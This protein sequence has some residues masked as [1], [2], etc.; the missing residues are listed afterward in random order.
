[1]AKLPTKTKLTAKQK[2]FC[3]EYLIDLNATAAAKRAGY[4]EKTAN[5][6][7]AQLMAMPHI[8]AIIDYELEARAKRTEITADRVLQELA[9]L[10]FVDPRNLFELDKRGNVK[11]KPSSELSDAD[12]ACI[13]GVTQNLTGTNIKLHD[14]IAALEKLGKHLKLFT[15]V[16]EQKHSFTQMGRVI[17]GDPKSGKQAALTF[18]VGDEPNKLEGEEENEEN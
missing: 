11:F 13:A 12:A 7:S 6:Q 16:S 10:A 17:V 15:D 2:A 18:N 9:K 14:K 8:K 5:E 4:S 3:K 1:M